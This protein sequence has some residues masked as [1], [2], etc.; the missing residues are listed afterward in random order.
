M[1][2]A[3]SSEANTSTSQLIP[4]GSIPCE[5]FIGK[6]SCEDLCTA[7]E[8][9]QNNISSG[10]TVDENTCNFFGKSILHGLHQDEPNRNASPLLAELP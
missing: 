8:K 1:R 7:N 3:Q 5:R 9:C 6:A 4:H 2:R 10:T